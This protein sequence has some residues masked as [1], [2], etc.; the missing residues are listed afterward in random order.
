MDALGLLLLAVAVHAAPVAKPEALLPE[1]A[2][3]LQRLEADLDGD[4]KPELV[5]VGGVEYEPGS[6]RSFSGE[7]E[8]HVLIPVAGGW[9]D[10]GKLEL[11]G[12]FQPAVVGDVGE[13]AERVRLVVAAAGQCGA[14]CSSVEVIAGTLRGGKLIAI[15]DPSDPLALFKG[16]AI[17]FRGKFLE[18]WTREDDERPIVECCPPAFRVE[19]RVVRGNAW[20]T[21]EAAKVLAEEQRRGD[22]LEARDS[23]PGPI[24]TKETLAA[25]DWLI[26]PGRSVGKVQLG[27]DV[28]S[29][30]A[31]LGS[32]AEERST[33]TAGRWVHRWGD[34]NPPPHLVRRWA[35][36]PDRRDLSAL[37]HR[38]RS[39][40]R[41]VHCRPAKGVPQAVHALYPGGGSA[42]HLLRHRLPGDADGRQGASHR[43]SWR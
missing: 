1:G 14:S 21:V 3:V 2:K 11:S 26:R 41:G 15:G 35:C 25:R 18:T 6:E 24:L 23:A 20:V 4:G 43:R 29:V 39:G 9:R 30:H 34:R 7:F 22:W 33:S 12:V 37:P 28:K 27:L 8:V 32:P 40:A 13:G 10:A 36:H 38:H 16:S 5:L 17:L 31:L 42:R 19:R